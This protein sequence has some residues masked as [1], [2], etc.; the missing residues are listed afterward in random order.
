MVQKI[1]DIRKKR[2]ITIG[3]IVIVIALLFVWLINNAHWTFVSDEEMEQR[4]ND[5]I[6]ACEHN[7]RTRECSDVKNKYDMDFEYCHSLADIPEIGK[8]IPIY[9]VVK[10]NSFEPLPLNSIKK[11][12]VVL[13]DGR[14]AT[15]N[16]Y[17]YYNCTKYLEE[18]DKDLPNLLNGAEP[19]TLGLYTL[20]HAPEYQ[21]SGDRSACTVEPSP[22]YNILIDVIPNYDVIEEILSTTM[23][24]NTKCDQLTSIQADI[25]RINDILRDYTSNGIVQQ[26]YK[27]YD[28][29]NSLNGIT[30][31]YCAKEDNQNCKEVN[32]C[33]VSLGEKQFTVSYKNFQ[34]ECQPYNVTGF[35][36]EM[37]SYL[38]TEDFMSKRIE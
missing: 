22:V 3:F 36:E 33:T 15:V 5:V 8:A 18:L 10:N 9:A 2:Y 34:G 11:D 16:K 35:V 1:K 21:A 31:L 37:K 26:Y 17:P 20:Y 28:D 30:S 38:K 7:E 23:A 19:T 12:N 27:N 4:M 13:K 24:N 6:S 32:G 25:G 14:Y 29:W